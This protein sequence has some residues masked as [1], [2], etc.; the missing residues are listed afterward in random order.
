MSRI[1]PNLEWLSTNFNEATDAYAAREYSRVVELLRPIPRAALL[2]KPLFGFILADSARRVGGVNDMLELA[3]STVEASRERDIDTHCDALNLYGVLLLESG[4]PTAARGAWFDLVD[5]ATRA[6]KATH[7]ARASNNLGVAAILAMQL[8]DAITAFRRAV[9]AYMRI[10]YSRGLAQSHQNLGIV[11]RELGLVEESRS[12]F[13]RARTFGYTG[14]CLDDVARAD[15][16]MAL[17]YVYVERDLTTATELAHSALHRFR[18]LAEPAGI[19]NA[20][21]VAGIVALANDDLERADES[22]RAAVAT[23]SQR[24][25][26]LLEAE[27]LMAISAL[28]RKR[29]RDVQAQQAEAQARRIFEEIYAGPW[30]EQ[31]SKRMASL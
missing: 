10:G 27:T 1:S 31:V 28:E 6:D 15:M 24:K 18:D 16:E 11:L 5:A 7:V 21:R 26:R 25:M 9:G 20:M 19:A 2:E 3:A 13:E 14:D 23:A 12:H 30:G 8:E 4:Q 29:S 22:L 17:L